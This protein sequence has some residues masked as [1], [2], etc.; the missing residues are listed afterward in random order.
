MRDKSGNAASVHRLRGGHGDGL[1]SRLLQH[2]DGE[3][4]AAIQHGVERAVVV[5]ISVAGRLVLRDL[6]DDCPGKPHFH[7]NAKRQGLQIFRQKIFD[8]CR[9]HGV[10]AFVAQSLANL[11]QHHALPS[12][13]PKNYLW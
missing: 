11:L 4:R 7:A 2:R 6:R 10:C 13:D 1:V 8:I 9:A 12:V 3:K 5:K